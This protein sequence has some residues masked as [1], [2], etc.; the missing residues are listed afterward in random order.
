[1]T[2]TRIHITVGSRIRLLRKQ[3]GLTICQLAEMAGIDGGFITCIET[4]KKTPSLRTLAKI[5]GALNVPLVDIFSD[6]EF[7]VENVYDHQVASQILAILNGKPPEEREQFLAVLKTLKN[8]KILSAIFQILHS[9]K[10]T[11]RLIRTGGPKSKTPAQQ[12]AGS[13]CPADLI[14]HKAGTD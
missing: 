11:R 1:M 10:R 7:K 12:S 6:Q 2:I 5:A 14:K 13:A 8:R 3:A 4:G 9:G